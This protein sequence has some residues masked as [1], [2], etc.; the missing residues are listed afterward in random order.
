MIHFAPG[1]E[2][3]RRS[4]KLNRMKPKCASRNEHY[5]NQ[6]ST[7]ENCSH[8]S[9]QDVN[10]S[11]DESEDGFYRFV[12]LHA[13][14]DIE[15]AI[16]VQDL[17]QNEYCIKPGIIFAEMPSGRHLLENLTDA[18]NDSAWIII[19]LT[20]NFVRDLWYEFQSYTSLLGALIIP[21]KHNSV[22]PMRPRNRP[23]PWERTPFILRCVNILQEDSPGFSVQVK[24]TFQEAQ[25][26][27]Q[28]KVWRYE[29]K[30]EVAP[31]IL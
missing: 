8:S 17:L 13:E 12:I 6:N 20:E 27:Q 30:K 26:R 22:I 19:L 3:F 15:E 7:L 4:M 29:R 14:E 31:K 28:E 10:A 2:E 18:I 9:I 23:L 21:H 1:S 24:K 25:Y 11:S 5:F 16:R